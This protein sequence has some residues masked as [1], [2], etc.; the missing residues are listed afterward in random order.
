MTVYVDSACPTCELWLHR[1]DLM[2]PRQTPRHYHSQPEI[3][4][5]LDGELLLGRRT[6]LAGS[7]LAIDSDTIYAF[8]VGN[9]GLQFINFRA[10]E[11]LSVSVDPKNEPLE[12]R[13]D[14]DIF[15]KY[16]SG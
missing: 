16:A 5:V 8:G 13:S 4:M 6:L 11:S 7:A 2:A 12:V 10:C 15:V 3:I 9:A 1:S 14:R